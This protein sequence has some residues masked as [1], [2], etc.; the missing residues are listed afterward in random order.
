[1]NG[2]DEYRLINVYGITVTVGAC[3]PRHKV[4]LYRGEELIDTFDSLEDA[5]VALRAEREREQP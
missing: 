1:M 3:L 4:A 5:E 2:T